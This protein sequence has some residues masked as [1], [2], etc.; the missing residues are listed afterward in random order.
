MP[1][2]LSGI[3]WFVKGALRVYPLFTVASKGLFDP[4]MFFVDLVE[5]CFDTRIYSFTSEPMLA[6]SNDADMEAD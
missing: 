2:L 1:V 3:L 4:A 5:W 6:R